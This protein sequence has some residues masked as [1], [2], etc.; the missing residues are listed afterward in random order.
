MTA[1]VCVSAP[2]KINLHLEVLGLRSDGF[3]ELA[4][5]MQSIDLADQLDCENTAD[6]TLSLSCDQPELSCG[7]DNLIMRA[8]RLLR[9]R[10]GFSE[11][12]ARMHLRKRIPIGAGLAGGSSDGAA[13]LVALNTLWSLGQTLSQLETLAADLGSD[14]PFCVAGGTQLCFGRGER[15]ELL[16]EPSVPMG[17]LLVKDPSISVSTPWAYGECKRQRFD[18][19]LDGESAFE[20]RRE[21]LRSSAWLH[22]LRAEAPPPL[23]ND[24][25]AVVAPQNSSVRK[26]L[27]LLEA[28]P[29]QLRA[30]MSGSGPSCFALFPNFAAAEQA[31]QRTTELFLA[32]G[33][34]SWSCSLLPHGVKLAA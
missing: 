17:V 8:A 12:G 24:L 27:Q 31:R 4:M 32:E 20:Q 23:R 25:Q 26:A 11:L 29:G 21:E 6:G 2:A 33:L 10:S 28:L 13:A 7:D 5:V 18:H 16:P 34:Q 9:Q 15:L 22:P 3:H 30:A 19:Y 14:M 1:P